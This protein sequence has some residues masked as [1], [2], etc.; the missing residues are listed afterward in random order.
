MRTAGRAA[1]LGNAHAARD[2]AELVRGDAHP[3]QRRRLAAGA[4]TNEQIVAALGAWVDTYIREHPFG[5]IRVQA[6]TL[7]VL[8]TRPHHEEPDWRGA[9]ELQIRRRHFSITP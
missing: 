1:V 2:V 9:L 4:T 7:R 5:W 6:N 3:H 8:Q